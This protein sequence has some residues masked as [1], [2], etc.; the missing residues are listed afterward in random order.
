VFIVPV[1]LLQEGHVA[2]EAVFAFKSLNLTFH[3]CE[4]GGESKGGV[5]VKVDVIIGLA[6]YK[7]DALV[8]HCGT[9]VSECFLEK[10]WQK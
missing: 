1:R 7:F 3:E 8:V 10:V 9:Q 5:V 4:V 6:L 2:L